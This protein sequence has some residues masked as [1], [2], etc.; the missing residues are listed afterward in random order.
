VPFQSTKKKG[1]QSESINN[2]F[3]TEKGRGGGEMSVYFSKKER[4]IPFFRNSGGLTQL[5]EN[6]PPKDPWEIYSFMGPEGDRKE[7]MTIYGKKVLRSGHL[8]GYIY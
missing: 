7:M 6:Q 3:K 1:V 8:L 4:W 2:I 5:G